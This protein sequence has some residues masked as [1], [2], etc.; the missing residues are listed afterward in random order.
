MNGTAS[1]K[2]VPEKTTHNNPILKFSY[3]SKNLFINFAVHPRPPRPPLFF[4]WSFFCKYE[5]RKKW[6]FISPPLRHP[7]FSSNFTFLSSSLRTQHPRTALTTTTRHFFSFSV[8]SKT[9]N[10]F[11]VSKCSAGY[12]FSAHSTAHFFVFLLPAILLNR[13]S[14]QISFLISCDYILK[15]KK[16]EENSFHKEFRRR[17]KF[18]PF[19][20]FYF[21]LNFLQMIFIWFIYF[22]LFSSLPLFGCRATAAELWSEKLKFSRTNRFSFPFQFPITLRDSGR[23]AKAKAKAMLCCW[24]WERENCK[25]KKKHQK[26]RQVERKMRSHPTIQTC[27]FLFPFF[28]IRSAFVYVQ[29]VQPKKQNILTDVNRSFSILNTPKSLSEPKTRPPPNRTMKILLSPHRPHLSFFDS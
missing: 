9:K 26:L 8:P 14:S 7:R 17:K 25:K 4:L 18:L 20:C 21:T 11:F 27:F 28:F 10:F 22:F 19:M 23:E 5:N 13:L 3:G 2:V 16:R 29:S 1:Y 24:G 12:K 6:I 15:H